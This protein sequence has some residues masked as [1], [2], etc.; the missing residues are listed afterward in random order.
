MNTS[1]E[2]G[3]LTLYRGYL[4]LDLE[5]DTAAAHR[6]SSEAKAIARTLNLFDLE[7]LAVAL[8]GLAL[9][10]GGEDS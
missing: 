3:W 9:V 7:V 4:A 10:R 1:T 2:H 8:E 6:R 5:N